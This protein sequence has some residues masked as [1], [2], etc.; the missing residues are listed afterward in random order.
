MKRP[1]QA[2]ELKRLFDQFNARYWKGGLPPAD[3]VLLPAGQAGR[4]MDGRCDWGGYDVID[5]RPLIE[6]RETDRLV[7]LGFLKANLLHEMI[8]HELGPES[9]DHRRAAWRA[10]VARLSAAGALREVI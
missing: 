4:I 6:L 1:I 10:A 9:G 3:I 5:G 7:H 2:D 8:H